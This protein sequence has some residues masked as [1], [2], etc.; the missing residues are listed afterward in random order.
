LPGDINLITMASRTLGLGGKIVAWV[1]YL[2]L[3]YALTTAYIAAGGPIFIDFLEGITG[4]S[5]PQ[6]LGPIPLLVIFGYFVYQGT[7]YVD[8]V[9]RVMMCGLVI[10]YV[11][12]VCFL[13]PHVHVEYLKRTEWHYLP[14]AVSL[15]ATSFGFHIIIPSLTAYLDHDHA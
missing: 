1:F 14:L 3:L 15:V 8:M 12:L 7:V 5:L 11:A 6:W 4:L 2:F 9:N 13:A 10:T